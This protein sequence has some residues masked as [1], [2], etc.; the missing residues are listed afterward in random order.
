MSDSGGI[1]EEELAALL[2]DEDVIED[3]PVFQQPEGESSAPEPP[4]EE[5]ADAG[6]T[7]M[8]QADIDA[9]L[10]AMAGDD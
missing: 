4:A 6:D 9:L 8:S 5:E 1:S 2:G 3:E 7:I 10:A